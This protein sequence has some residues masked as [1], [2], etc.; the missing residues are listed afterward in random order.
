MTKKNTKPARF[1]YEEFGPALRARFSDCYW[2]RPDQ[3]RYSE[4]DVDEAIEMALDSAYPETPETYTIV[5]MRPLPLPEDDSEGVLDWLSNHLYE[6]LDPEE[7]P[8]WPVELEAAARVFWNAVREHAH[9][10]SC[11]EAVRVVVD[12]KAWIGE[13]APDWGNQ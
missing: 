10:W 12:V 5:G 8:E 11:D 4:D 3:E 2:G 6:F 7:P 1:T 13:H 9:V